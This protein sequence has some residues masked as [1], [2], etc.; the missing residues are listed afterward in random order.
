M[1]KIQHKIRHEKSKCLSNLS[2]KKDKITDNIDTK[3]NPFQ[4]EMGTAVRS[5]LGL[6]LGFCMA[7]MATFAAAEPSA[8]EAIQLLN[9]K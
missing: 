3:S 7:P 5:S 1:H 8:L 9:G 2:L 4:I 6:A